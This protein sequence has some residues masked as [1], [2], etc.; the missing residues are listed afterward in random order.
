MPQRATDIIFILIILGLAWMISY[1]LNEWFS[2]TMPRHQLMQLPAMLLLGIITGFRY[3]RYI[4]TGIPWGIA[5]LILIMFSLIFWMLPHSID[6]AV[7]NPS[8]NRIMIVNM[9][10]AG[11]LAITVLR[12]TLFEARIIFLGM[13]SVMVIATGITLITFDIL[14]CSSFNI[15][16]QKATGLRLIIA[17]IVFYAGTLVIF[18]KNIG[19][20][21]A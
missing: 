15:D 6:I 5:I 1:P 2:E 20:K 16:Q 17:G 7:I 8:F 9:F 12:Q 4:K 10:V 11:F 18:F 21:K 14:L 13:V 3:S 19:K